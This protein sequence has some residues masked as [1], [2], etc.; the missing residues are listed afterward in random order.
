M[1]LSLGP[2]AAAARLAGVRGRIVVQA[3]GG[4]AVVAAAPHATLIGRGHSLVEL[5][6]AGRPARRFTADPLTAAEA[7]VA[8]HVA[9]APEPCIAGYLGYDLARVSY[10]LP[11]GSAIGADIPDLWLAAYGAVA[12]WT[13]D[14]AEIVAPSPEA[15]AQLAAALARP[16]PPTLAPS[17]G[18]LAPHDDAAHH[19]ARLERIRDYFATGEITAI[20]LA[21]R[22]VARVVAPGDALALYAAL[23]PS[24][25]SALLETDGVTLISASSDP[26]ASPPGTGYADRVRAALPAASMVGAPKLRAMQ[27][28][29]ELEPVRRGPYG[30]ALACGADLV[31][32]NRLAVIA[33]GELRLHLGDTL[34]ASTIDTAA[35]E[36]DLQPWI[37]ALDWLREQAI[38]GPGSRT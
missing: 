4:Q 20:H 13:G 37:A 26:L 31:L 27:L 7:F 14:T 3:P 1:A 6:R 19:L 21:R 5:D 38:A 16:A 18:P 32:A 30:G 25:S 29:D 10:P 12:R 22:L 8:D 9:G 15:C 34:T 33:H 23:A 36:R 35:T 28:L 11:G 17:F 24:P 2:L